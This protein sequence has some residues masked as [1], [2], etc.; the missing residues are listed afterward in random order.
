MTNMVVVCRLICMGIALVAL[1]IGAGIFYI[2]RYLEA[3]AKKR[4]NRGWGMKWYGVV[5]LCLV[6]A[7]LLYSM[8]TLG[9]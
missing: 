9:K 8:L 6:V 4:R 5:L 7:Y 1:G 3:P 2:G